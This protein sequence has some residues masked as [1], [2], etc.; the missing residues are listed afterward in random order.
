MDT[1]TPHDTRPEAAAVQTAVLRRIP[2]GRK[3]EMAFRMSE[4]AW[5]TSAAGVRERHPEYSAEDAV[6]A[7]RRMIWGDELY[8]A[9]YPTRPLLAP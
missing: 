2:G 4:D 7:V 6:H 9:V 3:V 1:F 5:A 8:A